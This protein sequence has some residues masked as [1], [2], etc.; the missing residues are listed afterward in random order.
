MSIRQ[1][2]VSDFAAHCV[3]EINAIQNGATVLELLSGGR[4]VAVLSPSAHGE[5][6]VPLSD[7]MGGGAGMMRYGPDYDPHAPAFEVEDWEAFREQEK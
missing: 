4:V 3:E 7:W 5:P 2:S 1:I 6:V